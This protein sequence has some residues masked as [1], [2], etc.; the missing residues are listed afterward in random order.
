VK[1]AKAPDM[2]AI[3]VGG[4]VVGASVA[5]CLARGGA[6]VTLLERGRLGGGTS[7]ASFAWT[8]SNNKTPRAYHDLNVEGMR[9]HAALRAEFGA[10]P[11][12]HGGGNVEWAAGDDGHAAMRRQ[13]QRLREW[14]YAAEQI[15]AARLREL[16]PD[17]PSQAVDGAAI[18][19]FP[20]EGWVET[21]VYVQVL[22]QAAAACGARLITGIGVR[23]LTRRGGRITG[24]RTDAG[25]TLEGDVVVNCAGR[26]AGEVGR[27]ADLPLP[28][29]PSRSVLAVTPPAPTRLGRVIH[30]PH[31]QLRPDGGGRV[32]VQA[33]D[34]DDAVTASSADTP[35]PELAAEL[36]R[37]A[38]ALL[39]GLAGMPPE[40]ARLGIRA[41]PA[42]GHSV[43]GTQGRVEGYYV[44][45]MHSGVTLAPFF[46]AVAAAEISGGTPDRRLATF[47]PDR[48]GEGKT[49]GR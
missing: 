31:C 32:M 36:V 29:S 8:N 5:Y 4:G 7:A 28:L 14:D 48:F 2:R 33:D 17:I 41:M 12:W 13:V 40:S 9:A 49:S 10:T 37:R 16:E 1:A 34:V 44:V 26:W 30:A 38:A 46:G 11:W 39:P 25:E 20:E 45:V 27:S 42:D 21:T 43:V 22:A 47:R 35:P 3:V 23:T 19:Y 18:A 24:V 6:A 15:T